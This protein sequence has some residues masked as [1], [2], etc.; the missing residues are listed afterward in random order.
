MNISRTLYITNPKDW[1][2]W[3]KQHHKTEAE[4]WLVYPR[5]A[6]GVPRIEYNDAVEEALCFGWIDSIIKTLDDEHTV[7][8]FSPRKP[9]AKYSQANI[10]RLRTLVAQKKVIKEVAETLTEVLSAEFIIPPDILKAVQADKEAWKNFQGFSDA[11]IRIRVAFIDG[12]RK[13]PEEFKKRLRHFIEMTA[14]N[15]QIGFG[16]I[17]KHY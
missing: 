4:I 16:G 13:R 3:L 11:Y 8:R 9:K 10:E 17:E 14:R 1:R 12:A 2:K 6:T 5:K 7:Q 15:K